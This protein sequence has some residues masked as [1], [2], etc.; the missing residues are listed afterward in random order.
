M[1]PPK[2]DGV[3]DCAALSNLNEPAVLYNLKLRYDVDI[4]YVRDLL[5]YFLFSLVLLM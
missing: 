1:N 4:I 3:D 2:F 5:T